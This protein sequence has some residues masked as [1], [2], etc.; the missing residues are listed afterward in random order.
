MP[1]HLL[2]P[3]VVGSGRTGTDG[4]AGQGAAGFAQASHAAAEG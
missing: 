4:Q 2:F 1:V 3:V